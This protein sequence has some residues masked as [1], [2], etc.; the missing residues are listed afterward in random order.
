VVKRQ[1]GG[2]NKK[3]AVGKGLNAPGFIGDWV[4]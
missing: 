4:F 2:R 3:D 1:P